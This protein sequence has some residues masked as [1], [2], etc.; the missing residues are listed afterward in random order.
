MA[1]NFRK[2]KMASEDVGSLLLS[3]AYY[4]VQKFLTVLLLLLMDLK[5][6]LFTLVKRI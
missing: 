6:I 5:H 2:A 4:V 1:K 3:G